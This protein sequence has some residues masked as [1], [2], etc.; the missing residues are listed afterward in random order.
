[1]NGILNTEQRIHQ[2]PQIPDKLLKVHTIQLRDKP[3]TKL[4][5]VAF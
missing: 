4:Y 1:M 5:G 2:P 3:I